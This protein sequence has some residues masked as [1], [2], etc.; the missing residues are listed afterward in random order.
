MGFHVKLAPEFADMLVFQLPLSG[1]WA[2]YRVL[3][4]GLKSALF[5]FCGTMSQLRKVML[6]AGEGASAF[7]YVDDWLLGTLSYE[8]TRLAMQQFEAELRRFGFVHAPHKTRGPAQQIEYSGHVLD[9]DRTRAG[10]SKNVTM[11]QTGAAH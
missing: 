8:G 10:G 11:H 5:L 6:Q 3:V 2:R 1:Q 4:F 9:F 7:V